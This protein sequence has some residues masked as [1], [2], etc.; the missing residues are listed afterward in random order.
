MPSE[1]TA[2]TLAATEEVAAAQRDC[3]DTL[4]R[5]TGQF[6]QMDSTLDRIDASLPKRRWRR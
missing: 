4:H 2:A 6:G 5:M 1:A 3:L